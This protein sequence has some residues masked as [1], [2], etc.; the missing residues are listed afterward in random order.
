MAD[1]LVHALVF[2]FARTHKHLLVLRLL[3]LL[4]PR[5]VRTLLGTLRQS[6][7]FLGNGEH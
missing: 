4:R 5:P 7:V 2:Y 3:L 6:F 1:L